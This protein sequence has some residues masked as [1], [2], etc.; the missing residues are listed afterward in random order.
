M[1]IHPQHKIELELGDLKQGE[2]TSHVISFD[3]VF[4]HAYNIKKITPFCPCIKVGEYTDY[5]I[6]PVGTDKIVNSLGEEVSVDTKWDINFTIKKQNLGK[7]ST[8]VEV[9][10]ESPFDSERFVIISVK[11]N[12]IK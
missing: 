2:T 1:K 9:S 10:L 3:N 6:F 5:G 12:V 7:S 8:T 4:E 11:Y